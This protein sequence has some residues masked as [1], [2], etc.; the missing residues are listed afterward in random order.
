MTAPKKSLVTLTEWFTGKQ[1][2]PGT[3]VPVIILELLLFA[4]VAVGVML[5]SRALIPDIADR[6]I[7]QGTIN[8][9]TIFIWSLLYAKAQRRT[10]PGE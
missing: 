7:L 3:R 8:L 10:L 1:F 4:G 2:T 9:I 5:G 6:P